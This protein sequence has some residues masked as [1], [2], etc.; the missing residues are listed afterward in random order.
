M[1]ILPFALVKTGPLNY[2]SVV[3]NKEPSS[4]TLRPVLC[5]LHG[6]DEGPPTPI[7]EAL[8]RH[9]PLR[10]GNTV[11]EWAQCIIIAPQ[12]PVRGD[13]WLDY[14]DHVRQIVSHVCERHAGDR[15]RLYLTGFSFGGNGVF[16]LSL[17]QSGQW[18]ALWAVD[19]TRVPAH[20]PGCPVWLTVGAIVRP[21]KDDFIRALDL[22]P[23]DTDVER[24]IAD[25]GADHV[26]AAALAYQ[27]ERIYSWLLSKRSTHSS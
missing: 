6:Y 9:G 21:R 20:D 24:V 3:P 1:G 4:K 11:P 7:A 10:S 25:E 27:D 18:A 2:L 8:T 15:K 5:F 14:A 26:G 12:M 19:P 22:K 23:F 13:T 17:H 16:D